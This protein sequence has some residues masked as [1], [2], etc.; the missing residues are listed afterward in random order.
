MLTRLSQFFSILA[1]NRAGF[2]AKQGGYRKGTIKR[3]GDSPAEVVYKA[4]TGTPAEAESTALYRLFQSERRRMLVAAAAEAPTLMY[5]YQRTYAS[6]WKASGRAAALKIEAEW[7]AILSVRG[8]MLKAL[9][10]KDPLRGDDR[11]PGSLHVAKK[12]EVTA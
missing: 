8:Q 1:A 12:K 7:Q 6:V 3:G 5:I 10:I 11:L 2:S 4:L 9:G